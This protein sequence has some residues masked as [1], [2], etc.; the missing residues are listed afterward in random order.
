MVS[1]A[2][3]REV[4]LKLADFEQN[5]DVNALLYGGSHV[6]PL[7]R[8]PAMYALYRKINPP[9]I[10]VTSKTAYHTPSFFRR[11]VNA[12]TLRNVYQVVQSLRKIHSA[13]ES[14]VLV[15]TRLK[16]Y[17]A[18]LDGKYHS[19]YVDPI[20]DLVDGHYSWQKWELSSL[21]H[22]DRMPRY[23]DTKFIQTRVLHLLRMASIVR[24]QRR[25]NDA[26][27]G[28]DKFIGI[29][30]GEL[31]IDLNADNIRQSVLYVSR[32]TDL[33]LILLK[34][35]KP[36]A[37]FFKE[38]YDPQM[39]ALIRACRMLDIKAVDIEHGF[40]AHHSAY[41]YWTAIPEGGYDVL[42]DFFWVWG[43]NW[44]D[45]I[46][47][48]NSDAGKIHR[49]IVGGHRWLGQNLEEDV[50]KLPDDDFVHRI[51]RAEKVIL[52]TFSRIDTDDSIP[53]HF[54][55]ALRKSPP[56]WLWLL[57]L[58]PLHSPEAAVEVFRNRVNET[59]VNHEI[60]YSSSLPLPLLL[61]H[62]NY[63]VTMTSHAVFEALGMRVPSIILHELALTMYDSWIRDGTFAYTDTTSDLMYM[64]ENSSVAVPDNS[65]I[66]VKRETAL[67]VMRQIIET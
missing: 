18:Q 37:V 44:A 8:I 48:S 16:N 15:F 4:V 12:T 51:R 46:T 19:F 35:I 63:H 40:N 11:I 67:A 33:F 36:K 31:D 9:P 61:K 17:T 24:G 38:Y 60:D 28:L 20:I 52:A 23:R 47:Q 14:D 3:Y 5:H 30:N 64:L 10:K 57:R 2:R 13:R 45:Y 6:W 43:Q 65:K 41:N 55:D 32:L 27:Q 26:I 56:G 50:L 34:S 59:K 21:A 62:S 49:P 66:E 42:P 25:Q 39:M 58:H 22:P 1:E 53:E 29:L 54:W 7:I